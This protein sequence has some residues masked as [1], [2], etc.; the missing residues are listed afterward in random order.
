MATRVTFYPEA[1]PY[2]LIEFDVIAPVSSRVSMSAQVDLYS[3]AKEE[4]AAEA[5]QKFEFPFTTIG[6]DELSDV[7]TAGDYYFLRT[8]LGWRIRPFEADHTLTIDGNLYPIDPADDIIVPTSTGA[9]V[10]V[11]L[12]RSQLT[13]TVIDQIGQTASAVWAHPAS[14]V[15]SSTMGAIMRQQSFNGEGKVIFDGDIG[16]PG[17]NWPQGTPSYPISNFADAFTVA[18]RESAPIIHCEAEGTLLATDTADGMIIEGHNALKVQIQASAG[19]STVNTQFREVYLRNADLNG[20]CV[21]RDSVLENVTGFQGVAHQCM[22][23][24]GS[25]QIT[26]SQHSHM[27]D[28]YSGRPGISTPDVDMNGK[29]VDFGMRG[30]WGGVRFINNTASNN[31][32]VDLGSGQIVLAS[33]CTAGVF[34]ARGYGKLIDDNGNDISTGT[35]NGMTIVNET[36]ADIGGSLSPTQDLRLRELHQLGGLETGSP[37]VAKASALTVA[38]ITQTILG[39][40]EASVT[41]TRI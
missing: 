6:G 21:F 19:V 20:W 8:D 4:W 27:L 30:Y 28:C 33:T 23:N 24:P 25:V 15:A 9:T 11:I 16:M 2:K 17:T 22:L 18:L 29:N 5:F 36:R 39:N 38:A 41:V 7:L 31:I 14:T 34:V 26:G 37:L 3:D 13:Q 32:S 1:T 40:P 10:A 12:E 35:W